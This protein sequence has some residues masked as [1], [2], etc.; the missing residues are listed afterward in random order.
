M[1]APGVPAIEVNQDGLFRGQ[2]WGWE[3]VNRQATLGGGYEEPSFKNGWSP[4]NK[5]YLEIFVH[6]LP[7]AWLQNV[8]LAKT[9]EGMESG[10][11]PPLSLDELMRYFGMHLLMSTL[12]G[13]TLEEYWCYK[14][15][16]RS[17]EE[18]PCPYNF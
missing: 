9:N 4:H 17:Q 3:G 13:W 18:G 1:P 5:T 2:S 7:F 6:F 15:L 11:S 14:P 8:L 12:Q 10:N 16:Q